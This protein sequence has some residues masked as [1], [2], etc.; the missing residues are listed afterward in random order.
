MNRNLTLLKVV[1]GSLFSGKNDNR[2]VFEE[3]E[4]ET[5]VR[6]RHNRLTEKRRKEKRK[7]LTTMERVK[8]FLT[9][10][11][12][13]R[14]NVMTGETEFARIDGEDDAHH[15][16]YKSVDDRALNGISMAAMSE[17]IDCWDRDV[18]RYVNSDAVVDYHPFVDYFAHL[19][20]WDGKDRVSE[21]AR[22][23]SSK[24]LW[25]KSFHTWMLGVVAQ[26][27]KFGDDKRANAVAPVLIS[28]EQGWG[29]STFCRMLMP[30]ELSRY[31]AESYDLSS[32][33]SAER[34]LSL[35]GLINLDEFDSISQK[36]QPML[37]NLMQMSS[38]NLRKMYSTGIAPLHRIASFIATS[39]SRELLCDYSGSR[40]FICVELENSLSPSLTQGEGAANAL[41]NKANHSQLYAQL[42]AELLAGTRY[43]FTKEEEAAIQ[44]SNRQ[45]YKTSPE[46]EIFRNV[47]ETSEKDDPDAQLLTAAEIFKAMKR[48]NAAA[49]SKT[50]YHSFSR[51]LP[52]IA[53]RIHRKDFNG[54]YVK[55]KR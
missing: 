29:K 7:S 3:H 30:E 51:L 16:I 14:H 22:M 20:E 17:G 10:N 26:W 52:T 18:N 41:N 49:L 6:I 33:K 4:T 45:F 55:V 1:V 42:K 25:V 8:L 54:Y 35:Y 39:N 37:K 13:F 38:L 27:M 21:V 5:V 43:W 23:V 50:S 53:K 46:E 19:P 31:Y 9:A 34:K 11:Y 40:R 12:R 15:I 48:D 32:R 47:F 24:E 28:K 44:E 2:L 36:K